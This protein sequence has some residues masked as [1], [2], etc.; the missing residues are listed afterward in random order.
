MGEVKPVSTG[1]ISNGSN[2]GTALPWSI[3]EVDEP[4]RWRRVFG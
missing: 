2:S 3:C 1:S 4:N